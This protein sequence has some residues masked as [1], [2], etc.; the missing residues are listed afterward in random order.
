MPVILEAHWDA[1]RAAE[2]TGLGSGR[3]R[4][5]GR[6]SHTDRQGERSHASAGR[7][8]RRISD[9]AQIQMIDS[10]R[11][12]CG[13]K[14]RKCIVFYSSGRTAGRSAHVVPN[15]LTLAA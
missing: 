6:G 13:R 4:H 8:D 1:P 2:A 10:R 11:S 7:R 3:L 9:G 15:L 5:N 12:D 14:A